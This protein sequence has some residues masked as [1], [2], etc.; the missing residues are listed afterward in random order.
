MSHANRSPWIEAHQPYDVEARRLRAAGR[1]AVRVLVDCAN[2]ID[3]IDTPE[4]GDRRPLDEA[5]AAVRQAVTMLTFMDR[6]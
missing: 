3:S 6:D 5:A 1:D 2:R 4:D